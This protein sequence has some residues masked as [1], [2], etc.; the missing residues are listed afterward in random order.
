MRF[1][2]VF[3]AAAAVMSA[4]AAE[5]ATVEIRDAVARV[6]VVPSDRSDV[7][8]EITRPNPDL[9]VQVTRVG[10][11]TIVDGD[12]ARKIH[13]CDGMSEKGGVRVRGVGRVRW[14]EMPQVVIYTPRDVRLS[15][16]GAVAGV[17]GRSASLE[18][19]NSGCSSW[20]VADVAGDAEV[21]E[22]GA[23]SIRM[24]E[25]RR[26]DLN[27]SGAGHVRAARARQGLDAQLSGAGGVRVDAVEGPVSARVSGVG[28]VK[29]AGGHATLLRASVSGIGQVE[30][31]GVADELDATISGLGKIRVNEVTGRVS[32]SVSGGGSIWVGGRS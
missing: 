28:Q 31:E 11:R 18:L 1:L 14:D 7:R 17:V 12:L 5:A 27:L 6:T 3:A 26:L 29:V 2:V 4:G 10:D 32:K 8:V 21:R 13:D 22:S 30:F 24:G 19:R 15:A 20:T 16:N 23:G 25:A 9:P